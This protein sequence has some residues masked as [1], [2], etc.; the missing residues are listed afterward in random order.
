MRSKR[1]SRV[2]T[3]LIERVRSILASKDLTLHQASRK[4]EK[5]YG[6]S[7]PYF[8]P[9]NLYF[10]LRLGTSS[11]SIYQLSSL[12][13][14][15]GYRLADWLQVFGFHLE[16]ISR[17]Q[18][19]LP[20]NRTVLLNSSLDDPDAWV[21]WLDTRPR[22]TPAP[23]VAPLAHL[24]EFTHRRRL[25]SLSEIGRSSISLRKDRQ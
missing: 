21:P 24:L 1:S 10:D 22:T 16:D 8:L 25:R 5:L 7:S 19:Q 11:P 14:I 4:S 18:I 17:L 3:N 6:R 15:S 12:S 9:H 2:T 13:R 20:S 23:P